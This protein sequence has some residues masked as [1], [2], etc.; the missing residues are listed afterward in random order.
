MHAVYPQRQCQVVKVD[1]A[2]LYDGFVEVDAAVTGTLPVTE[3]SRVAGQG[4]EARAVGAGMAGGDAFFKTCQTDERLDGGARWILAAQGAVK[5][6]LLVIVAQGGIVTKFNAVDKRIRVV[7][8][9]ADKGED[10]AIVRIDRNCRAG[11]VCKGLFSSGLH[12][13][14]NGQVQVASGYRRGAAEYA[15]DTAL[16][17]RFHMLQSN[18]AMQY[19]FIG[20]FYADLAEM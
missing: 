11:V 7:G 15:D 4:I 6:R 3:F 18:G 17:C 2:G 13:G 20:F 1:V 16:C 8:R 5:Q 9:L 14:I 10:I 12:A 19:G